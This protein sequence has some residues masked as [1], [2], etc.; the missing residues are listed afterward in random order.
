M[1]VIHETDFSRIRNAIRLFRRG[2]NFGILTDAVVAAA[3]TPAGLRTAVRNAVLQENETYTK[4]ALVEA[5]KEMDIL[6]VITA[7]NVGPLTTFAGLLALL[8]SQVSSLDNP[9]KDDGG[10]SYLGNTPLTGGN[11][12]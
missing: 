5:I 12:L 6:G 2:S 8:T 10:E 11:I 1:A 9:T 3:D 7:S 4:R